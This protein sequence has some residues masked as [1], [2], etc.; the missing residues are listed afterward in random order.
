MSTMPHRKSGSL[1]KHMNSS[2]E[3]VVRANQ[4]LHSALAHAYNASEP[5]FRVENV[6]H[7]ENKLRAIFAD[8]QA[9][10]MLDLGCGT[11]FLISIA[12]KY[13]QA[14]DGVDVTEAMLAQVDHSGSAE[15]RLHLADTGTFP[16]EEGAYDVVTAY[17]FL[18]HLYDLAPTLRTAAR[19]LRSG[20]KFYADLEPNS[21]FW[22]SV[23][24]LNPKGAHDP[25]LRR[26][27]ESVTEKD[28]EIQKRFHVDKQVFNNA[29][30][31]KNI[32]GGFREE[33]LIGLLK[34]AGFTKVEI[35]YYWFLGQASIVNDVAYPRE[36]RLEMARLFACTLEKGLPLTRNLF[37][38]VGF[39]ATR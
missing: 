18:H 33:T 8:T 22:Q 2:Y 5:H 26:E 37:K 28:D 9:K 36:Q 35:S 30:Y 12:R 23:K 34:D 20:G 25:I 14:I 16:A 13:V 17:S 38:Y 24:S 10:R 11:G 39:V 4:Q 29:E 15:I 31:H 7:V 1:S 32:T 21:Y 27:I 19:A 3:G 6:M